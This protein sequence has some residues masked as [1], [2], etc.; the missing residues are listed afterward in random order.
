MLTFVENKLELPSLLRAEALPLLDMKVFE[1]EVL[2]KP[3]ASHRLLTHP[4]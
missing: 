2:P 3:W 1:I 4:L